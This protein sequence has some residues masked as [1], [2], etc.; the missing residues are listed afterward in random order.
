MLDSGCLFGTCTLCSTNPLINP[1]F[2]LSSYAGTLVDKIHFFKFLPVSDKPRL[3]QLDIITSTRGKVPASFSDCLNLS[4]FR[5]NTIK[6]GDNYNY[7]ASA[8]YQA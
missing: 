1:I 5:E 2:C 4:I 3:H 6:E 8:T 7:K